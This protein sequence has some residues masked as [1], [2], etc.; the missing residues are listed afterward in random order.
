MKN[1][2]LS[3]THVSFAQKCILGFMLLALPTLSL[4]AQDLVKVQ[5]N[6]KAV[7]LVD[8]VQLIGHLNR[9]I[10]LTAS[11]KADFTSVEIVR[12]SDG[13]VIVA[14]G[15]QY[16]TAVGLIPSETSPGTWRAAGLSCTTNCGAEPGVC[17]PK[18]S[19]M[20]CVP[21]CQTGSCDRTVS[22]D[23]NILDY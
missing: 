17:M 9:F 21:V 2:S 6:G 14:R 22:A 15:K 1:N 5:G 7:W 23:T 3:S 13:Y 11:I 16:R 12:S 18:T 10:T 4:K 19:N 8:S 20:T